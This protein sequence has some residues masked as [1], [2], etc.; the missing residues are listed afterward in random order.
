M[1]GKRDRISG[2]LETLKHDVAEYARRAELRPKT[3]AR[4]AGVQDKLVYG[5]TDPADWHVSFRT[6]SK[7]EAAFETDGRWPG[8]GSDLWRESGSSNGF[9]SS[10]P[11]ADWDVPRFADVIA[12]WR[13]AQ[14]QGLGPAAFDDLPGVTLINARAS[15]P[16]RYRILRH[17]PASVAAGGSDDTGAELGGHRTDFYADALMTEYLWVKAT[18]TPSLSEVVWAARGTEAGA[19]FWRLILPFGDYL[20][21]AIDILRSGLTVGGDSADSARAPSA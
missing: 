16:R 11:S 4:S 3:L 8:A 10:H 18:T 21:S 6:L 14:A 20:V 17:A 15:D 12:V 2:L 5:M 19:Y 9:I 1:V 7:I 13:R